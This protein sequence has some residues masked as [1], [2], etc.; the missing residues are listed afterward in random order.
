MTGNVTSAVGHAA[1]GPRIALAH[2]YLS[3]RGGAER[4]VISLTR[5]F[6]GVPLYTSVFDENKYPELVGVDV[7]A[8]GLN[9]I[10]PLRSRHRVTLPFLPTVYGRF[11]VD[12]DVVLC[13]SSGWAHGIST[14]A[15]KVVYCHNPPRWIYQRLEYSETRKRYYVASRLLDPF[16]RRWDQR[17]ASGCS[18]YIANSS[19]VARRIKEIYGR[20]AEV[21]PP[22]TTLDPCGAQEPV[23]GIDPGYVVSVGRLLAYKHVGDVI[24][25]FRELP[26]Q[27]LVVVGNGPHRAELMSHAPEN[28][29][30]T[31]RVSD[32]Q[33]RWLYANCA[34]LVSASREDFGL[35]PVEAALFG[36]PSA[37]LRAGGFLDTTVEGTTGV[38]FD[39]VEPAAIRSAI[40]DLLT[41]E[42]SPEA[43]M[44]T[45]ARFSE[46][47]FGRRLREIVSSVADGLRG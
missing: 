24:E 40:T 47:G 15:P 37:V 17:V 33:L 1:G 29:T 44:K 16:L 28:V 38:F 26:G 41:T 45:A 18:L 22:P 20:E 19:T 39:A 32:A 4:V 14:D 25:A 27:R 7:R 11:H 2:D 35:T 13:S 10:R 12:A 8:S 6:P 30:F 3:E 36:K 23:E 21:L 34:G 5:A 42:W 9:R 46:E 31:G 43:I